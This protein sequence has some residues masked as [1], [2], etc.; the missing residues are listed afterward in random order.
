MVDL[1]NIKLVILKCPYTTWHD[2]IT[3]YFFVKTIEL[4]IEGYQR[5]HFFGVMPFDQTDFVSD[6]LL[7][8][9][10]DEKNNVVPISAAQP[11]P[12]NVQTLKPISG[13][14]S[15]AFDICNPFKLDFTVSAFFKKSNQPKHFASVQESIEE[16][17]KANRRISYYSSWTQ[18]PLIR[19]NT[20]AVAV[21][22][23][24]F[25]AM[26]VCHH[27][28]ENITDLLGL[29][30]PK[31]NTDK[32][33]MNWGFERSTVQGEPVEN[34]PLAFLDGIDCVLMHLRHYSDY[35]MQMTEKYA[36]LWND[37]LV[38]GQ[39]LAQAIAE[40]EKKAA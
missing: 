28:E 8:C 30:L 29:G 17:F 35:A 33:F 20:E 36:E 25:A 12:F 38:V 32:F 1:K 3:Q 19:K 40:S 26:T 31:F 9:A 6:H 14:K 23:E 13:V 34:V 10:K 27:R 21:M 16:C 5:K 2:P 15:L 7:I 22:K 37:R 39:S 24:I 18:S 4:K 11:L